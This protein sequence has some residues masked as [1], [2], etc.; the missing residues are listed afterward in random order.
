MTGAW[1]AY[2][3]R[4]AALSWALAQRSTRNRCEARER[5][6]TAGDLAPPVVRHAEHPRTFSDL[7][8]SGRVIHP[9]RVNWACTETTRPLDQREGIVAG[10]PGPR[11]KRVTRRSRTRRPMA[12]HPGPRGEGPYAGA[13]LERRDEHARYHHVVADTADHDLPDPRRHA[14]CCDRSCR[15]C[16]RRERQRLS[17]SVHADSKGLVSSSL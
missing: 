7:N 14:A 11:D 10:P 1:P 4:G 5:W 8:L 16:V 17:T 15:G 3:W 6:T 9:T 2:K 13:T 12:G